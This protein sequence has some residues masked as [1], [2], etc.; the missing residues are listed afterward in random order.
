[1]AAIG[2]LGRIEV[3]FLCT[4]Q[5][6]DARMKAFSDAIASGSLRSLATLDLAAI[7]I[8]AHGVA[9]FL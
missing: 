9:A 5:I 6:S 3:L 2:S 1:M 7:W 8:G 4:D